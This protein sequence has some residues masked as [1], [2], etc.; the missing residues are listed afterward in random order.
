M[1]GAIVSQL[2]GGGEAKRRSDGGVNLQPS[3][4]L[5]APRKVL[6]FW[7]R[8]AKAEGSP[9]SL[10]ARELLTAQAAIQLRVDPI[11]ALRML[12]EEP[13]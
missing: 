3:T 12:D 1:A 2:P 6:E 13:E 8:A 11:A 5:R 4:I 7:K 10:W 9:F